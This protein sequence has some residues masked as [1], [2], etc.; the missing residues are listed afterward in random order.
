MVRG[1]WQATVHGVSRVGRDLVTKPPPSYRLTFTHTYIYTYVYIHIYV[2]FPGGSEGKESAC[3]E[4]SGFEPWIGKIPWRRGW[5]PSPV[6]LSGKFHGQRSPASYSPCGCKELDMTERLNQT[7][8]TCL[9]TWTGTH[10]NMHVHGCLCR[11]T[12][13]LTHE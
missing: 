9:Y 2:D 10:T 12:L 7:E 6:S 8:H 5:Q 4:R 11:H 1:T 13:I 3:D